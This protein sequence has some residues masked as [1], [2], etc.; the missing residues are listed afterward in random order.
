MSVQ[1]GNQPFQTIS[2]GHWKIYGP[3]ALTRKCSWT[4]NSCKLTHFLLKGGLLGLTRI[5]ILFAERE[6]EIRDLRECP[7]QMRYAS[8][9]KS[10]SL[11]KLSFKH[12]LWCSGVSHKLTSITVT[13]SCSSDVSTVTGIQETIILRNSLELSA[14]PVRGSKCFQI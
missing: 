7:L 5:E 11:L 10:F 1:L 13:V 2:C 9:F 3:E 8:L 4:Q 14:I 6:R 12:L